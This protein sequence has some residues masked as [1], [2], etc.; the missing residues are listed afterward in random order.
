MNTKN[1]LTGELNHPGDKHADDS[2]DEIYGTKPKPPQPNG[3][4]VFQAVVCFE[5]GPEMAAALLVESDPTLT[6]HNWL[7]TQK[8]SSIDEAYSGNASNLKSEL[9]RYLAE[10]KV[11]QACQLLPSGD[12]KALPF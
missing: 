4:F 3:T 8:P 6:V 9:G 7:L 2:F 11:S 5:I 10:K 1:K 12:V